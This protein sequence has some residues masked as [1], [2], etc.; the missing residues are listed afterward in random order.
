MQE[1]NKDFGEWVVCY[2]TTKQKVIDKVLDSFKNQL[3]ETGP[4][5]QKFAIQYRVDGK[6]GFDQQ[7]FLLNAN[8][9]IT[10]SSDKYT[11]GQI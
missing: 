7:L 9:P 1:Q 6:D 5:L 10:N 8:Q 11:T 4:T 3:W 2:H